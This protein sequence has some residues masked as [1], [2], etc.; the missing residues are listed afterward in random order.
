MSD[1]LRIILIFLVLGADLY[2]FR[3]I[4][5]GK[6][7]LNHSLLWILG[8]LVLL[9]A[10]VFPGTIYWLSEKIGIELPINMVFLSFSFFAIIFFVYLTRVISREDWVNRRLTQQVAL[11]EKRVRELEGRLPENS[12]PG[13]SSTER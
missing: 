6:M 13:P 8:S 10:A 12:R 9:L 7:N 3:Q 1:R 5:R 2:T 11:L 4:R